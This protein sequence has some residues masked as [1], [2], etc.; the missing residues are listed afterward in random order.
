MRPIISFWENN[1]RQTRAFGMPHSAQ[2]PFLLDILSLT[3]FN[4]LPVQ[5][6]KLTFDFK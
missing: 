2:S 4:I 6:Y 1:D 5:K 3:L